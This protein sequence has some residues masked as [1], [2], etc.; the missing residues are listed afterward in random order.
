MTTL[1]PS[2]SPSRSQTTC[3]SLLQELQIIWD[4]IGESDGERDKMLLELEQECLNIYRRK[5][6]M[7]RRCKADLHN[8]LAQFESEIAKIV[9]S[10]G[11]HS[12]SFSRGKGTLKHQISYIRP[13]LEELRSKKKQRVKEFTET[14]LQ[15]AKI[16]AE[17]AGN[18]QSMMSSDPQVDERDL[19]VKK[20]GELKSHLQELQ[21]EKIIRLQ[22][23]DSHISMIH[24]LSVLMPFDFLKTVSGIHSSLID[25]ANGQSRS[26][27]NDTLAKLTGV[28][29]SLQQEKQKRLQKLQCLGSTLIELWDLLDTPPDERKRFEHVTSLIS[30][31]VDEVLR[32]GSLGL[33]IIEQVELQVQSL[34]VLKASKMKE[35]VLKRQN[36]LEE[37]YR[38]V[39]VDVNSDAARQI[40]INLIESD[41]VDLSNLL[42]SMDD[43]IAK[44]KQEA[45]SRKDILDKVDKWK[46]ASEEEKWLDDYEKDEN[47][48]SAG[49]GVHKNLKRA[50]KARILV[51][52]LPSIVEHL[53]AKVK[54]WEL[55][56][57]IPFLYDKASLLDMLEEYTMLRQAREDEKRRSREQKRL[58]EQFAAEQEALFGSRP[59]KPLAQ[60][61]ATVGTPTSRRVS[62]PSGKHGVS[63]L[64]ERRE[65]GR[66]NNVIPLNF[67]A[68]PKNDPMS[69][70]N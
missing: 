37:I 24:E 51:S 22:K 48:Y 58:Q 31:S 32:Q 57:G 70:G 47:R 54:A 26:I 4:E 20:L 19:T 23:V 45:L 52:K 2:L 68:L 39:H 5:V 64:K 15:I 38:G 21:N 11:E 65:T 43:Q 33:D 25:S 28:V 18:G 14:Q 17:I 59:K 55:E 6:E 67:V 44:A 10:L 49:R 46:H 69:R 34:N 1:P 62:T 63:N 41:N 66:V 40:L 36:E 16:C 30:S 35:L 12:F 8:S 27:S 13:V 3:A 61:N 60:T 42:S 50:E 56:K 7:T 53:T 9:S 29:N